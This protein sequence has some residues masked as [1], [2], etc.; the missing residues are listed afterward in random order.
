[1]T[2]LQLLIGIHAS[3]RV[4][5]ILFRFGIIH[6]GEPLRLSSSLSSPPSNQASIFPYHLLLGNG[7]EICP[8]VFFKGCNQMSCPEQEKDKPIG[9]SL[10][11]CF[12]AAPTLTF[13]L[14]LSLFLSALR[15]LWFTENIWMT[16]ALSAVPGAEWHVRHLISRPLG[17]KKPLSCSVACFS[18][19]L[20]GCWSLVIVFEA[21]Q[22]TAEPAL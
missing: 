4:S 14:C 12:S 10:F 15:L 11:L 8:I 3:P 2:K 7:Q 1:M 13:K 16:A 20:A 18:H 21:L 5:I 19:P 22:H 17:T 9:I 6:E